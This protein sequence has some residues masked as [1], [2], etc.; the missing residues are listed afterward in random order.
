MF[1]KA[2]IKTILSG[3]I[4]LV[5]TILPAQTQTRISGFLRDQ[6][7][8]ERLIGANILA[9]T[10]KGGTS[11]DYNGYFSIVVRIPCKLKFSYVGYKPA[12]VVFSIRKDTLIE[13]A[14]EPGHELDGVVVK[15]ARTPVNN[16]ATLRI[17]ELRQLPSLGGKPD[18]LKSMQLLPGIQA[19]NEGSSLLLVRGGDPGQN[20][21]LFDN[22]P[23][24]YV[25]HLG[26]FMSVFNLD[27]INSID[28]YKG[29]FPA[30][31]GG[32]L[33]S[34]VDITQREGNHASVKGSLSIG[35]TDVS[36]SVEGPTILKNSNF[37]ITGRKTLTEPIMA[38]ATQLMENNY[39]VAYGFHD[40]NGKFTWK[41]NERNSLHLNLYQGDDYLNFWSTQKSSSKTENAHM[42]NTWGNWLASGKW[43]RVLSRKVFMS[44]NLSYSRYRLKF[45]QAYSVTDSIKHPIFDREFRSSVADLSLRS[46]IKYQVLKPWSLE[47]GIQIS[48]LNHIPN[49]Y[50]ASEISIQPAGEKLHA[51]ETAL[52]IDNKIAFSGRFV[53]NMGMRLVYYSASGLNSVSFEPRVRMSFILFPDQKL[54]ASF[55][56][57]T[58]NAQLLFTTGT[59]MNSEVWIPASPGIDPA[60]SDQYTF[61]WNGIFL[62]GQYTTEITGYYKTMSNLATYREGFTNLMGDTDWRNK[63]VTGGTG[64]STGIE[65]LL[66]KTYGVWTGFVSC[67]WSRTTRHFQQINNG[68]AFIFDFDRPYTVSLN[69]N[70]TFSEKWSASLTW[71]YHTGLPYT[72]V[73]G[74]QLTLDTEPDE[75][76][77][78]DYYEVLHYGDRNSDRMKDYHRLDVGVKYNTVTKKRS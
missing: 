6:Q 41:P 11:T 33:S 55:Q 77:N 38:L 10:E 20:L 7:T 61:G 43:N 63:V 4:L 69:I 12:E 48:N 25:N 27:I 50:S 46:N 62:K 37:I 71:I 2:T 54:H 53:A 32:R 35:V 74:R 3:I 66:K 36:L 18:V 21:Y 67:G 5:I 44:N 56:R 9:S 64:T 29:G 1:N 73:L 65:F 75:S 26:G 39:T 49:S 14:L 76:G 28:L 24:I 70:H 51:L 31:Y 8:G 68:K 58:Q 13:V 42:G 22:V 19:Q 40:L 57:V 16:V 72:P 47:S 78:L 59:I 30:R 60:Q 34:V 23:V 45:Y 15:G 17:S 52:Y